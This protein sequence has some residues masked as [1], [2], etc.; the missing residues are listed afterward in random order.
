MS[1]SKSVVSRNLSTKK[2]ISLKKNKKSK[3]P[4]HN[5]NTSDKIKNTTTHSKNSISNLKTEKD[6]IQ[7]DKNL[8]KTLSSTDVVESKDSGIKKQR[9]KKILDSKPKKQ[10]ESNSKVKK[11][12]KKKK[13]VEIIDLDNSDSE[14]GQGEDDD[15]KNKNENELKKKDSIL[16]SSFTSHKSNA[17]SEN[18]SENES[19]NIPREKITKINLSKPR[20][21]LNLKKI[22]H[23]ESTDS[24]LE[25]STQS[26]QEDKPV[27]FHRKRKL[28]LEEENPMSEEETH[29][30]DSFSIA[31]SPNL[32]TPKELFSLSQL[33]S[34]Y[35]DF[36]KPS[37][38]K[39]T[40]S[41][42]KKRKN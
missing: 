22:S 34:F 39:L 8:N 17:S 37:K 15:K 23:K 41:M 42:R 32:N 16:S 18:N 35:D 2:S 6:S 1:T 30:H 11:I 13:E 4:E 9:T 19:Q 24:S 40:L 36:S 28:L 38:T 27:S 20:K 29:S 10:A 21:R 7:D 31:S 26:T 12:Q 5:N 3:E 14:S 25:Q 33:N